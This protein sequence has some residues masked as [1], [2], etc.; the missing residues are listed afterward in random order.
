MF[1]NGVLSLEKLNLLLIFNSNIP[2]HII[3]HGAAHKNYIFRILL[4]REI[5]F[6]PIRV[7]KKS[8]E[9]SVISS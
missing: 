7:E 8:T 1:F 2:Y 4:I 3:N 6:T 5:K 9:K